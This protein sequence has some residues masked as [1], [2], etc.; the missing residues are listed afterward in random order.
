MSNWGSKAKKAAQELPN[1]SGL[2]FRLQADK[3]E[4][5]VLFR[6]DTHQHMSGG[7]QFEPRPMQAVEVVR[8]ENPPRAQILSQGGKFWDALGAFLARHEAKG[9]DF[10]N[11]TVTIIR[12]GAKGDKQTFY[13]FEK[14]RVLS[15]KQLAN[16]DAVERL[17]LVAACSGNEGDD[18]A[19]S[20]SGRGEAVT[21][22]ADGSAAD[23]GSF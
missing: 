14:G 6:G 17:D 7:G 11:T 5:E 21:S 20:D 13:S 22:A 19:S 8:I 1:T 18:A 3:E 16:I 23:D 2:W 10:D 9:V 12:N 4:A 15:D